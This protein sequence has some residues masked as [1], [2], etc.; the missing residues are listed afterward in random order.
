MG[1]ARQLHVVSPGIA[2]VAHGNLGHSDHSSTGFPELTPDTLVNM[3]RHDSTV[4]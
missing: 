4:W 3:R 1:L 2:V